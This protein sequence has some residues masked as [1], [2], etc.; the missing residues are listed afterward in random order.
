M[1]GTLA[2][3]SVELLLR[4]SPLAAIQAF[5]YA[6]L[7]GEFSAFA[8]KMAHREG[9]VSIFATIGFLLGNGLLAFLLNVSSFQTNK[10]AGAL[11]ISVC[12]NLKQVLTV[13]LGIFTFGDFAVDVWNGTGMFLAMA[14]CV[15]YSKAELDSKRRKR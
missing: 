2:L 9:D 12:G 4:M 8:S 7:S 11:A 10:L 6:L 1:T 13:I 5:L 14:G 3:P 15:M